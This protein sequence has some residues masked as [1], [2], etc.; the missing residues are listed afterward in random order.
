MIKQSVKNKVE[1]LI[2]DEL[3]MHFPKTE[4][5]VIGESFS[6]GYYIVIKWKENE[7]IDTVGNIINKYNADKNNK[8]INIPQVNFIQYQRHVN[9][10]VY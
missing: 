2:K 1:Q 9:N 10:F 4:F 6:E 5:R 8:H 7:N 3:K